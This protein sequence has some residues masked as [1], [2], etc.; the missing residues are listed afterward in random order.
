VP[1]VRGVICSVYF[2]FVRSPL[3]NGTLSKIVSIS[4][5]CVIAF[6]GS[7]KLDV[8]LRLSRGGPPVTCWLNLGGPPAIDMDVGGMMVPDG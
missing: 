7:L 3:A 4:W 2:N 1:V 5:V 6:P 8:N